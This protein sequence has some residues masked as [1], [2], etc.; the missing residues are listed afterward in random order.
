MLLV[1]NERSKPVVTGAATAVPVGLMVDVVDGFPLLVD[2]GAAA[3]EK[4][5][6]NGEPLPTR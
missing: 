2:A 5:S 1:R 6:E 4:E 3:T